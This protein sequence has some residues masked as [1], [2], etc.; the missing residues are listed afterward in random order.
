MSG[1]GSATHAGEDRRPGLGG[2]GESAGRWVP[3][4][5]RELAARLSALFDRDVAIVERLN[6]AQRRLR[7]ANERLWSGLAPDA[8]GLIYDGQAPAGHSQ[9]AKL[10]EGAPGGGPAGQT[11]VLCALQDAHWVIGR[12]FIDY[13]SASEE[14]RQLAVDVGELSRQLTEVLCALGWRAEEARDANVHELARAGA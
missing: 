11:A 14:R 6:D 12:A 1:P 10:S 9:I 4:R 13:Q 8:F 3:A 5:A 2:T 7:E